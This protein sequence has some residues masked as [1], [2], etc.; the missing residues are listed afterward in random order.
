M[1]PDGADDLRARCSTTSPP[2]SSWSTTPSTRSTAPAWDAPTPAPGWSIRHQISHLT[3][4][5]E[6]GALAAT[7][8]A[9]FEAGRDAALADRANFDTAGPYVSRRTERAARPVAGGA[10]RPHRRVRAARPEGPAALV[11]AA[12]AARGRSSPPG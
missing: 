11:R 6:Q 8:P 7:D 4:F 1:G 5:D 10:G 2:S 3:T 9:A 12:D